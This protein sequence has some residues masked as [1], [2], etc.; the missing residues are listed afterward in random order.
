MAWDAYFQKAVHVC[1]GHHMDAYAIVPIP[2]LFQK[3]VVYLRLGQ[4]RASLR[5]VPKILE[6]KAQIEYITAKTA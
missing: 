4:N 2:D 1:E 5:V 6:Q 3:Y